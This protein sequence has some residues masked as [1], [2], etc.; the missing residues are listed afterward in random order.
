MYRYAH[1]MV[2]IHVDTYVSTS[3][4]S[5]HLHVYIVYVYMYQGTDCIVDIHVQYICTCTKVHETGHN[6][7]LIHV[8]RELDAVVMLEGSVYEH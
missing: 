5:L 8:N 1:V 6:N 4:L 3:V 2:D 7:A